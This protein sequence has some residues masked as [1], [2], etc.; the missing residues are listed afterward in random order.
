MGKKKEPKPQLTDEE[1]RAQETRNEQARISALATWY[2][3]A[4]S[5]NTVTRVNAQARLYLQLQL[6]KVRKDRD[7]LTSERERCKVLGDTEGAKTARQKLV[8]IHKKLQPLCLL[9]ENIGMDLEAKWA[10][11]WEKSCTTLEKLLEHGEL[12]VP[13]DFPPVNEFG[14]TEANNNPQAT[15]ASAISMQVETEVL[16]DEM[17]GGIALVQDGIT[18]QDRGTSASTVLSQEQ[19]E[20]WDRHEQIMK[21]YFMAMGLEE[22][23]IATRMA[24]QKSAFILQAKQEF[25][26][27]QAQ[28]S[29]TELCS[30][31]KC[32]S[33]G[34]TEFISPTGG[35]WTLYSTKFWQVYEGRKSWEQSRW[36]PS[37]H[38]RICTVN[39]QSH[40]YLDFGNCSFT[41]RSAVLPLLASPYPHTTSASHDLLGQDVEFEIFFL[42]NANLKIRFPADL[43]L[44]DRECETD[45]FMD[46]HLEF[47]G[48]F[49]GLY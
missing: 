31:N 48:I 32:V 49:D 22:H 1:L 23:A 2:K 45:S 5:V 47:A 17:G 37:G 20:I 35:L 8:S 44:S 43:L 38:L 24:T 4:N 9:R 39:G 30:Q 12:D 36:A 14:Q 18:D 10:K 41:A 33:I 7:A 3:D 11:K 19:N 46:T 25:L 34:Y 40:L 16:P 26:L 29:V 15:D 21:G 27:N 6:R 42:G 13:S 28:A